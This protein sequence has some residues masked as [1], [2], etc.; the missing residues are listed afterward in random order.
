MTNE[1]SFLELSTESVQKLP[2]YGPI[3]RKIFITTKAGKNEKKEKMFVQRKD[4]FATDLLSCLQRL[5]MGQ[6]A[7]ISYFFGI[8]GF[9]RIFLDEQG[10]LKGEFYSKSKTYLEQFRKKMRLTKF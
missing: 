1:E 3:A 2:F 4:A 9:I 6:I 7:E 5:K 8:G 10:Q